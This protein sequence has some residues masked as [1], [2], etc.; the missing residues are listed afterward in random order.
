MQCVCPRQS[1]GPAAVPHHSITL[2]K[3]PAT[4]DSKKLV[5]SDLLSG[6]F[7]FI[8]LLSNSRE[9]YHHKTP[10]FGFDQN[11]LIR[12][13]CT[14]QFEFLQLHPTWEFHRLGDGI[15]TEIDCPTPYEPYSEQQEW[16]NLVY[17]TIRNFWRS[18]LR[19]EL[20]HQTQSNYPT[21]LKPKIPLGNRKV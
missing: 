5:E 18:R 14:S 4:Q 21:A 17:K 10:F 11:Y 15:G 20:R 19:N 7:G 3:S 1:T 6:F 13:E 16:K 12:F 9:Q 2:N 8:L